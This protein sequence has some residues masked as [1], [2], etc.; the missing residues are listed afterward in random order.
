MSEIKEAHVKQPK[1]AA[2]QMGRKPVTREATEAAREVDGAG[3]ERAVG[4]PE[5]H[6]G[7]GGSMH[8]DG[9]VPDVSFG[10]NN[11]LFAFLVT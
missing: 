4:I 8:G 7:R 2:K 6:G 5:A 9:S 10:S 11:S 3:W 1:Q